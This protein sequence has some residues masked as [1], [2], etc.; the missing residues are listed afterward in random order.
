MIQFSTRFWAV[1]VL[2]FFCGHFN[3]AEEKTQDNLL[4]SAQKSLNEYRKE[5][6]KLA[7][8]CEQNGLGEQ[9]GITR[10]FV[11]PIL[12]EKLYIPILP[13]QS[14]KDLIPDDASADLV[15][16]HDSWQRIRQNL[17]LK[18][19]EQA[20]LALYENRVILAM[21]MIYIALHVMPD[22]DS[23]RNALGYQLYENEWRTQWEIDQLKQG[24][25]NHEKF[26]WIL[27]KYAERY[28][29]GE[30]YNNPKWISKE[31][32]DAF[33]AKI[34]N[35]W[36][37]S[38]EH[39]DIQ[40]N[41]S[42]EEGVKLSRH[43]EI[44]YRVWKQ[45]FIQYLVSSSQLAEQWEGK[46]ASYKEPRLRI[47]FFRNRR[48]Y[49]HTLKKDDPK[50]EMSVGFYDDKT[51]KCYF[52]RHD[53]KTPDAERDMYR[54]V[55]HEGTHQLF[56]C[57][58]NVN[59]SGQANFWATEAVAIY[60]ETLRREGNY[61]VL[62]NPQDIRVLSAKYRFFESKFYMPF[63]NIVT[64]NARTFQKAPYLPTLYSQCGG[65]A[66]FL[67]HYGKGQYRDAFVTYLDAVY[68]GG[69]TKSTLFQLTAESPETLDSQYE[70]MLK[71]I[72]YPKGE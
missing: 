45:V 34:E 19:Q 72:P 56:N 50:I 64:L 46:S 42:I 9:A 43:L 58:K 24:K 7:Q 21:Q 36:I 41:H 29:S 48:D 67:M 68:L 28:E 4:S 49:I 14:Q 23:L 47:V 61:Y 1:V 35:G 69:D 12:E 27:E 53:D 38:T 63:G 32:D 8:W 5:A 62:G 6:E 66:Y 40:T 2:L 22:N 44:F 39:Y 60:M 15:Y 33:H 16:W 10:K 18:L 20:K 17:A 52:Y 31:E 3:F 30:R 71:K 59:P 65:M 51:R 55:F 11:L 70:E 37:I 25:I 26:G 13:R 57:V 54:T